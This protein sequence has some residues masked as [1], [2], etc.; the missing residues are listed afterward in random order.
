[1]AIQPQK[2]KVKIVN[3]PV[4][5]NVRTYLAMDIESSAIGVNLTIVS[6]RG[7]YRAD[8]TDSTYLVMVGDYNQEKTE[9]QIITA[10]DTDNKYLAVGKLSNSHSAADPV[11]QIDFNQ[12]QVYGATTPGG[13][14]T[15]LDTVTIDPTQSF[16]EYVYEYNDGVG[17]TLY[18]YFT[19]AYYNSSTDVLSQ[20]SEEIEGTTFNRRTIKRIIESGAIKALTR[21]EESP[22]AILNWDNCIDLV[23]DGIDEISVRMRKWKFYR[24]TSAGSDTVNDQDWIPQPTNLS[25]MEFLRIGDNQVRYISRKRFQQLTTNDGQPQQKGKPFYYTDRNGRFYLIPTPDQAYAVEYDFYYIPDV[26]EQLSDTVPLELVGI[27]IYYT[28]AQMAYIRGNDKR[29]DKMYVMFDK[30]LEQQVEEQTGPD[31]LGD[32]ESIEQTNSIYWDDE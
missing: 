22:N 12:I 7:F 10:D 26:L 18:T 29:G 15:L 17:E 6:K 9:I 16:T 13:E 20:Y 14:K 2:T 23:Q 11:T 32:A 3:P 30:L 5:D 31:Q 1:M 19:T 21:V 27:L 28:A 24:I 8:R 25:Q 4:S